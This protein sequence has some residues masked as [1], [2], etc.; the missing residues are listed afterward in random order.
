MS[1][2][3]I[4]EKPRILAIKNRPALIPNSNEVVVRV[5][6][7]GVCGTDL[8]I[9]S[10]D[11][12]VPLP[13]IL[14]HEFVGVVTKKGTNVDE[15]WIG[16]RVTGEINNTCL[17][18]NNSPPCPACQRGFTN[19]CQ[20]RSVTGIVDHDGAFAEEIALPAGVLHEISPSIPS[21]TAV[22]TEP[23]AATIQ[24]FVLSPVGKDETVAV[25]GAGRLGGLIV[26]VAA[27]KGCNVIAVSRS[28]S[29]RDRALALGA[30]YAVP[31]S[32]CGALV[33]EI[34]L[35]LGA[36]LVVEA[37]GEQNG[38]AQAVAMVRPRGTIALKTTCGLSSEGV[39]ATR[40]VVDEIWLQGS[41][42]GPFPEALALLTAHH[43]TLS[44][45]FIDSAAIWPFEQ[46][47][48]AMRLAAKSEK[49]VILKIAG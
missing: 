44:E 46:I 10:G 26:F 32:E 23:L 20:C 16:K 21:E 40:L 19:H 3:A 7:A 37:T 11:Y 22:L 1:L 30:R 33:Q 49:K 48:K 9:F 43:K 27:Q 31:P 36:D 29:K 13:L 41:R 14:G 35:G 47:N 6:Y 24:T 25:L 39:D 17:V 18:N 38:L 45:N 5:E 34:T 4:L 12:S 8:A 28:Q 15:K 42:C 2:A